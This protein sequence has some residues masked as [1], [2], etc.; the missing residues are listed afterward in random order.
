M[1]GLRN[2]DVPVQWG[3]D[4]RSLYVQRQYLPVAKID[5]LDLTTD[6]GSGEEIAV[7]DP[8]GFDRRYRT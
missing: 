7:P 4:G 1:T 2:D 3:D 6:S 5:R 8:A